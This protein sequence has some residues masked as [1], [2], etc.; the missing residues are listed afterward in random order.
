MD[1]MSPQ[2]QQ[3]QQSPD[4]G[5]GGGGGG[6]Q[7]FTKRVSLQHSHTFTFWK[8][9]TLMSWTAG[10]RGQPRSEVSSSRTGGA[11]DTHARSLSRYLRQLRNYDEARPLA[12]GKV[13][14]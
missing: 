3:Q 9:P 8:V 4:T 2:Q 12:G 14:R 13:G 1:H 10:E 7:P 6:G 5:G 11:V